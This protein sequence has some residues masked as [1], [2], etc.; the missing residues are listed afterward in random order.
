MVFRMV[1]RV[2]AFVC[3]LCAGVAHAAAPHL[4]VDCRGAPSSSPTVILEAG[5][6]GTSADWQ[7]VL[8]DL[9]VGGRV[10]AYDRAG[11]GHSP[12]ADEPK[13]VIARAHQLADLLDDMGETKPVILVGHSN[14]A[15]YAEAFAKLW[16]ERVAGLVYVN[17]VGDDDLDDPLLLADLVKERQLSELAARVERMGF[18]PILAPMLVS[19]M[20]LT[21]EAAQAKFRSLTCRACVAVARDEDRLLIPGLTAVRDLPGDVRHIPTVVIV[22]DTHPKSPLAQAF[23][24]AEIAPATRADHAW[25]LDAP[26]A[27]HVSPLSRDRAYVNAAVGWLR[28]AYQTPAPP[29]MPDLPGP[30]VG[31]PPLPDP[32]VGH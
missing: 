18:A 20:R 4:F 21:G 13:D 9:A 15:I 5:A 1:A 8:G 19:Q 2:M 30:D 27:T 24:A 31:G 23:H 32:D 26:G 29:P 6:F 28:A 12:G 16:P 10:C 14:G 3:V 17:G 25:I 22:G 11:L 7:F